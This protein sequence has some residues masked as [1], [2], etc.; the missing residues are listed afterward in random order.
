VPLKSQLYGQLRGKKK[1]RHFSAFGGTVLM[2]SKK[3]RQM[4]EVFTCNQ[5]KEKIMFLI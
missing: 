1:I 5:L 3:T 2:Q 4:K